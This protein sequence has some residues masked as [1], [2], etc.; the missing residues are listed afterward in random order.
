MTRREALVIP[1]FAA[2][3]VGESPRVAWLRANGF[4]LE[5]AWYTSECGVAGLSVAISDV[6][7]FTADDS[8]W[9]E[10]QCEMFRLRKIVETHA[11]PPAA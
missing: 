8:R 4:A 1:S 9:A 5:G 2:L 3:P 7:V 10:I 11:W 6:D